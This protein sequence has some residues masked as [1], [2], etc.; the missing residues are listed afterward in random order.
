M[1]SRPDYITQVVD[2][3]RG[4]FTIVPNMVDEMGMSVYAVRL[5]LHL[6]RVTGEGGVCWQSVRTLAKACTMSQTS[7]V[8]AKRELAQANLIRIEQVKSAV[9]DYDS[10][11]ITLR[12]IWLENAQRYSA[13]VG[14]PTGN[15]GVPSRNRGVPLVELKKNPIKKNP[16]KKDSTAP[17]NGASGPNLYQIASALA[18][19]TAVDLKLN[20]GPVFQL[21]KTFES[22]GATVEQ[23]HALYGPSGEWYKTDWRGQKGQR[24]TLSQIRSTWKAFI[25][26]AEQQP[27]TKKYTGLV[28]LPD[29]TII[30]GDDES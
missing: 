4:H 28:Q 22:L 21:A 10:D 30:G 6:K 9:G 23:I 26:Q 13:G 24:P 8:R 7:V 12:D 19:V 2:E 3:G 16:I 18:E 11:R 20:R 5:Y 14:V 29:G 15:T 1:E 27:T 17:Q 25:D